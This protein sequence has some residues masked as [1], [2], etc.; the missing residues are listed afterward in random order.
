MAKSCISIFLKNT[1]TG[2]P[3]QCY[4]RHGRV[5]LNLTEVEI[6][7]TKRVEELTEFDNISG[8]GVLGFKLLD[9]LCN[10][11]ILKSYGDPSSYEFDQNFCIPVVACEGYTSIE[12]NTLRIVQRVEDGWEVELINDETNWKNALSKF[13][14]CDI[15]CPIF[16]FGLTALEESWNNPIYQDGDTGLYFPLTH[17]GNWSNP[18]IYDED[19][20][21]TDPAIVTLP[22]FRPWFH[23]L[24]LL[25]KAFCQVGYEF[26]SPILESEW[27][28]R[29]ITYIAPNL[30][31]LK[32]DGVFGWKAG[33]GIGGAIAGENLN[34]NDDSTPPFFDDSGAG[35]VGWYNTSTFSGGLL[36]GD[37]QFEIKIEVNP[38][39]MFI[40]QTFQLRVKI[41]AFTPTQVNYDSPLYVF[42]GTQTIY[43]FQT[44][45]IEGLT[46]DTATPCFVPGQTLS[47]ISVIK[48]ENTYFQGSAKKI[49]LLN[50]ELYNGSSFLSCEKNFLDFF[51]GVLHLI[52]GGK[53]VTDEINKC[54]TVYH[55]DDLAPMADGT[56]PEPF[57]EKHR[58][59]IGGVKL[60]CDKRSVDI[61]GRDKPRFY[62]IGFADPEDCYTTDVLGYDGEDNQ[63]YSK[64]IDIGGGK[65][66]SEETKLDK[67]NCFEPTAQ[68]LASD[69]KTNES[70]FQ[71]NIIDF[72]EIPA[73]WDNC[74]NESSYDIGPRIA[75]ACGLVSQYRGLDGNGIGTFANYLF[76]AGF[77][78]NVVTQIPFAYQLTDQV[79]GDG[80]NEPFYRP[81]NVLVY[82][83]ERKDLHNLFWGRKILEINNGLQITHEGL[84]DDCEYSGEDFRTKRTVIYEGQCYTA[85]LTGLEGFKSCS[86]EPGTLIFTPE[87]YD[88]SLEC[89]DPVLIA[90][91][92]SL[93]VVITTSFENFP[94]VR[95]TANTF[96]CNNGVSYNWFLDGVAL[97]LNTPSILDQGPGVYRVEVSGCGC[98]AFAQTTIF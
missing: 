83:D 93:S 84:F 24:P 70:S 68:I 60:V 92:C 55:P 74:D 81:Q 39:Q 67:N 89:F 35:A 86:N 2:L 64:K 8:S 31:E 94:T 91:P 21:L 17:Y 16:R 82:G 11:A 26:K 20:I 69:L 23:I 40:G 75:L 66:S 32:K 5:R 77:G 61:L 98:D 30:S 12:Q 46:A 51:K 6:E 10:C 47:D 7:K 52:G 54:V 28:R 72:P 95:L 88:E 27:G 50:G 43:C 90:N 49:G 97:G 34:F 38:R 9:D 62:E 14:M 29:L 96:G 76:D 58:P 15:D 87:I 63:L 85:K 56:S 78:E 57:Y 3:D 65:S 48:N 36:Q 45:I 19:G 33:Y 1:P 25:R 37:Y 71:G 4:D 41:G 18:A 79:L 53:I 42:D 44:P 59:P 80:I 73:L 13:K 22:D